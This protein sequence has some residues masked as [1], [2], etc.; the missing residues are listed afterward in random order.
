MTSTAAYHRLEVE[1][2]S[3]LATTGRIRAALS[4]AR[5]I[6]SVVVYVPFQGFRIYRKMHKLAVLIARRDEIQ[7]PSKAPTEQELAH[8]VA[9]LREVH[10]AV[11]AIT[12]AVRDA[13]LVRV[14]YGPFLGATERDNSILGNFLDDFEMNMSQEFRASLQKA[15]TELKPPT[16]TDW[17]ASLEAMRH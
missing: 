2:H 11:T 14:A 12:R 7:K 15:I 16:G 8:A 1:A 10:E 4:G 13:A 17:R 6:A 9:L 5:T 3:A